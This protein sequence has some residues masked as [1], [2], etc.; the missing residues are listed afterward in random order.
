MDS[1]IPSAMT[2][3]GSDNSTETKPPR[4]WSWL[5]FR[6]IQLQ[7]LTTSERRVIRREM[8]LGPKQ[9][10]WTAFV[11]SVVLFCSAFIIGSVGVI[12]DSNTN[13]SLLLD[14]SLSLLGFLSLLWILLSLSFLLRIKGVLAIMDV[15]VCARCGQR[16]ESKSVSNCRECNSTIRDELWSLEDFMDRPRLRAAL[17]QCR[18]PQERRMVWQQVNPVSRTSIN[19]RWLILSLACIG[20]YSVMILLAVD[21]IFG[22]DEMLTRTTSVIESYMLMVAFALVAIGMLVFIA[23][24]NIKTSIERAGIRLCRRCLNRAYD[25]SQ[26]KCEA[27]QLELKEPGPMR[28]KIA[29]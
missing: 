13:S 25:E 1:T 24:A 23:Q 5:W 7:G 28:S 3:E 19:W 11:I 27:C 6:P 12:L 18:S 14:N 22:A 17:A 15:S 21:L 26:T 29:N 8:R 16:A 9:I 20:I 10:A 4:S 2:Q